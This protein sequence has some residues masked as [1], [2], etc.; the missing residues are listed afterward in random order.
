[1]APTAQPTKR[2]R[3]RR[4]FTTT[5]EE[6]VL[7]FVKSNRNPTT[8]EINAA[9]KQEGRGHTADNSLTKLVKE[10]KLKRTPLG[11]GIRGSRFTV[12]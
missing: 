6:F 12:G 3:G 9:W 2:R 10:R 7:G 4:S 8:Q 5:A 11:K 1:M